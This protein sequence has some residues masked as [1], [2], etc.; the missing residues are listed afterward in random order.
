[1]GPTTSSLF[2]LFFHI[3]NIELGYFIGQDVLAGVNSRRFYQEM[4]W[5]P[6]DFFESWRI[7]LQS[8]KDSGHIRSFIISL[9][10]F[11]SQ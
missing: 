3:C 4:D 8:F 9:F 7:G 2:L 11:I 6:V 5:V 10:I 1:M